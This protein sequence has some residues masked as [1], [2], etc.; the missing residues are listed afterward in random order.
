MELCIA[1]AMETLSQDLGGPFGAA[2]A[3]AN[4]EVISVAS[5]LVLSSHDP[6]AHAEIN[7]IRAAG[8]IMGSHDLSGCTL[9]ATCYPCPMCLGAVMWANIRTVYYGCSPKDAAAIG[10]RDDF[11]YDFIRTRRGDDA[12]LMLRER[13]RDK[14][15][16]LFEE[17]AQQ[18]KQL[19]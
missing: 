12:I 18:K 6:T 19:Y 13:D 17:Y 4:G 3:D 7:A 15:L 8:R 11:M 5:N 9:Y 14:C 1:R 16:K 10:F 2:I